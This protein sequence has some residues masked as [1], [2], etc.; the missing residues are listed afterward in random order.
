[1]KKE[2]MENYIK[3]LA[4][5]S[6]LALLISLINLSVISKVA[7][8]FADRRIVTTAKGSSDNYNS[9]RTA[10]SCEIFCDDISMS[11]LSFNGEDTAPFIIHNHYVCLD[12]N[13]EAHIYIIKE[14]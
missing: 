3:I 13:N 1:M 10:L 11:C 8:K 6:I 12:K 9:G 7:D 5:I 14:D 2:N 4:I